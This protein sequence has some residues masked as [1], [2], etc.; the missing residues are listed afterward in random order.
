MVESLQELNKNIVELITVLSDSNGNGHNDGARHLQ[1]VP[2]IEEETVDNNTTNLTLED[3]IEQ[4]RGTNI[5]TLKNKLIGYG[6][7]KDQVAEEKDKETIIRALYAEETGNFPETDEDEDT[8]TD[9]GVEEDSPVAKD[10]QEEEEDGLTREE[11]EQM[12]LSQIKAVARDLGFDD[13]N[14]RGL[15]VDGVVSLLFDTDENIEDEEDSVEEV[16]DV[17]ASDDVEEV[18]DEVDSDS[19]GYTPEELQ[20]KRIPELKS[21]CDAWELSYPA[22]ATAPMLR[23]MILKAQSG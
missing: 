18:D 13:D 19:G 1:L 3:Y 21:I 2:D 10:L 9:E 6:Y 11:A 8:S 20:G 12:S 5:R 23:S 7:D 16:D 4:N 17:Y 14:L 22:N 15:D